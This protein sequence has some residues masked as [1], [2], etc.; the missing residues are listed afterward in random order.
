MMAIW[1]NPNDADA[2]FNRGGAYFMKEDYARARTDWEK[3]LQLEP[4][5]NNAD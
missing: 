4:N 1:L 5:A 3:M 2:Y